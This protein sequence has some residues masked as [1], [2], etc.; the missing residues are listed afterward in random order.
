MLI[1]FKEK[2]VRSSGA[3]I[4]ACILLITSPVVAT[5]L[6]GTIFLSDLSFITRNNPT[7]YFMSAL[8]AFIEFV[9]LL[10]FVHNGKSIAYLSAKGIGNMTYEAYFLCV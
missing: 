7:A 4:H 2:N 8:L 9:Q 5:S 1:A 3:N 10:H 6:K